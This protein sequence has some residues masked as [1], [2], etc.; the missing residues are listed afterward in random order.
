VQVDALYEGD[1]YFGI[2]ADSTA[3]HVAGWRAWHETVRV[4]IERGA[5]VNARDRQGIEA[6][7]RSPPLHS[8]DMLFI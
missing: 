3:L 5:A 4:L 1:P 2:S 7:A 6:M 8:L